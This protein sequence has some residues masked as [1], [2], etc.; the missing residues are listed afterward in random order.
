MEKHLTFKFKDITVV[1][2]YKLPTPKFRDDYLPYSKRLHL[3]KVIG[4]AYEF[5]LKTK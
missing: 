1:V 2:Y 4:V 3:L 5:D